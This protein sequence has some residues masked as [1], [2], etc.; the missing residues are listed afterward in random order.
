MKEALREGFKGLNPTAT[1]QALL[2]ILTVLGFK[3][4]IRREEVKDIM[5]DA[6]KYSQDLEQAKGA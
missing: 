1:K 3:D 5:E 6:K 4:Y 2:G